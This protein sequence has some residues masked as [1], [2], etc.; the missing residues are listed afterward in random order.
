MLHLSLRSFCLCNPDVVPLL[1]VL[2]SMH[3]GIWDLSIYLYICRAEVTLFAEVGVND[4]TNILRQKTKA[5]SS[6][7]Q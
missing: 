7:L 6:V 4:L 1:F 2:K 3:T 5:F